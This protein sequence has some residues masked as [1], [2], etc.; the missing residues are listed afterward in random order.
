V[1]VAAPASPV[2]PELLQAG[3]ALLEAAGFRVK[4]GAE[5]TAPRPWGQ[6]E[7]R[8]RARALERAW[9]DP[10]VSAVICARGGY[11]SFKILRYLRTQVLT[12]RP[13]R[14]V[15]FSDLTALLLFAA[16]LPGAAAFHGPTV[17]QLPGLSPA[18]RQDLFRWLAAPAPRPR[19]FDGL[20]VLCPGTAAGPLLGGNLTTLC[21]LV[22]TPYM[23]C[24]RGAIL[25]L[26]DHNEA[27][28]RLDRLLSH[29][30]LAKALEGVAGVV[31]GAFTA[32]GAEPGEVREMLVQTLAPLEV[33]VLAGLPVGHQ[34][35]NFTLPLG[36]R[37]VVDGAGGTL[38]LTP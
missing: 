14:L 20:T 3:V 2:E 22:G 17:A 18:A 29:L 23:P 34:G 27:L 33:P 4:V 9:C 11:G 16:R 6:A 12:S 5:V 35:D 7:D 13:C 28:Y 37:A 26:E 32:T 8:C 38:T 15:G 31:L 25:F 1:A 10:E 30:W 36:V 24:L 21:H 19:R